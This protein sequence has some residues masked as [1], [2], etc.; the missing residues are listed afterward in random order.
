MQHLSS[1]FSLHSNHTWNWQIYIQNIR[2]NG[3]RA[4]VCDIMC[5]IFIELQVR[6]MTEQVPIFKVSEEF[7]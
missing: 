1:E 7:H 6:S 3:V 2:I 5:L 4:C